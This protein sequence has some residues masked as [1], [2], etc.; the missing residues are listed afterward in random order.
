MS[1]TKDK[2]RI[3]FD[4]SAETH[5]KAAEVKHAQGTS[6]SFE[7]RK[8]YTDRVNELHNKLKEAQSNAA[9]AQ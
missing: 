3:N 4:V 2:V 8:I 9:T 6:W 1:E 5:K 7:M